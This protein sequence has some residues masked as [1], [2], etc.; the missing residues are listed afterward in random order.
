MKKFIIL[1]LCLIFLGCEDL[2]TTVS[3]SGRKIDLLCVDQ[4]EYLFIN[5]GYG[6]AIS[7]HYKLDG[8]LYPCL[9]SEAE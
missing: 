9:V 1:S 4:V 6:A 3:S 2:P 8:T 5:T 7:P